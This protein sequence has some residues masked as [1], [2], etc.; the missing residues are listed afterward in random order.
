[1]VSSLGQSCT[2]A[3]VLVEQVIAVTD[4][5]STRCERSLYH[6][7]SC[8]EPACNRVHFPTSLVCF[9]TT[10]TDRQAYGKEIQKDIDKVNEFC[11]ACRAA[12]ERAAKGRL[13]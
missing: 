10:L 8:R 12:Q 9:R 3:D 5:N 7:K 11:F 6:P 1:M 4:C 2:G 13:V